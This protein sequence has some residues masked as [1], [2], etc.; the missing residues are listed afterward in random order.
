MQE[1]EGKVF[2]IHEGYLSRGNRRLHRLIWQKVNGKIP[3]GFD[4]HHK[5]GNK[6]NNSI[7]NLECIPHREHLSIHMKQNTEKVHAWHKSEEGRKHLGKKA[8]IMMT[9]RPFKTF[10]CPQCGKD[11]D[12]QNIYRVKYCG[13]N[14]QQKARRDRGDDLV[15]RSCA[16]CIKTFRINKYHKTITCGYDCG[17]MIRIRNSLNK[18]KPKKILVI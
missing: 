10:N 7:E 8:S 15:D 9:K 18:L 11:F 16:Y 13:Q 1:F 3:K 4:I 14:C 2:R 6:L 17:A 5:D 12:S